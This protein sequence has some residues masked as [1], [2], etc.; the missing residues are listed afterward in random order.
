MTTAARLG[1]TLA[2]SFTDAA[3]SGGL[4]FEQRP[5]LLRALDAIGKDDVLIVAK[6]DRLG[7]DVINVAMIES[8]GM[9]A[10]ER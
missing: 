1:L 4:L 3:V 7:R 5:A 2:D 8:G 6:R 9:T 10:T